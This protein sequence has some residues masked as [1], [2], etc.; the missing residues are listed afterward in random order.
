MARNCA[1]WLIL[2]LALNKLGLASV[3]FY[4][5]LSKPA[6]Q[7]ILHETKVTT[8]F[9][10]TKEILKFMECE[11]YAGVEVLVCLEPV[12]SDLRASLDNKLPLLDFWK[13]I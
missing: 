9:A 11:S 6:I 5:A 4:P 10:T 12:C 13:E 8:L 1:A 2:D 7:D 3:P